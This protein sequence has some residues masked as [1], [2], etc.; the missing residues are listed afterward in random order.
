MTQASDIAVAAG[1]KY[2]WHRWSKMERFIAVKIAPM[3]WSAT[4]GKY[5]NQKRIKSG[6]D[7]SAHFTWIVKLNVPYLKIIETRQSPKDRV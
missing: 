5:K 7:L 1:L 4:V 3:A 6:S 2:S